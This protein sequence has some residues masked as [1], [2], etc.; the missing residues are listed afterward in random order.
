MV[1]IPHSKVEVLTGSGLWGAILNRLRTTGMRI[2]EEAKK[3]AT[4][5]NK[6]I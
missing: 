6:A 2:N 3:T 5:S 1:S 4:T